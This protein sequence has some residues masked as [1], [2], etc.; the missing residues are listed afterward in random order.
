MKSIEVKK[1]IYWVGSLDPGLRIFDIIMYTPYGTT[2]N[3]YVVKGTE[4]V[5]LFETVKE[6]TFDQYLDRLNNMDI[7]ISTIDYIVVDHTEP[8]HA[9]S[10]G[11][12]LELAPNAKVVGSKCAIGFLR[13][14]INIPF[15]YIEVSDGDT[16]SLGNKTLRFISAPFLHWPD[17]I[18]T[19]IE[20]DKLLMTCDSF[21]SHYCCNGIFNDKIENKKD[22]FEALEYYFNM[23]MGPFKPYAAKAISKIEKLDIDI[24]CPGH[25]PVL[26]ENPLE[27][28]NIYKN[29]CVPTLKFPE[30]LITICYVS[31]YGYT[32]K[33]ANKIAEGINTTGNF[34]INLFDVINHD[35]SDI[36]ESINNSKG[37]LFGTPTINGDA[38]KPI[39]DVLINLNPLTHCCKLAGAFG[40]FGWSGEG[41]P[42]VAQRLKQLKMNVVDP[43]KFKFNPSE[44]ELNASFLYGCNFANTLRGSETNKT[45]IKPTKKWKCLVCNE[46]FEGDTAPD[47]CPA[48]GATS[49]QFIEIKEDLITFKSTKNEHI[50]IIGNGIAGLSAAE[51]IRARNKICKISIISDENS[52]TYYRPSLSDGLGDELNYDN[53]FVKPYSWYIDNDIDLQLNSKVISINTSANTLILSS[54]KE[55]HYDKLI[56]AN[57]SRNF[58][59]PIAGN[60]KKGVFTL[61]N[62]ADLENI[63]DYLPSVKTVS[64]IG[65]GILGVEA[66]VSLRS[67]GINVNVIEFAN[68]LMA[69]QLD[70]TA[71]SVLERKLSENG[72]N[73]ITGDSV[74]S[75][76]GTD[77]VK[78]VLLNSNK[79]LEC[80]M[81]IFSVGI[82]S[83]LDLIKNTNI[84]FDKGIIVNEKMETNI[85][86]I[87]ACGDVCEYKGSV[88][89]NWA[90]S[91]EMG[92]TAGIAASGDTYKF[93]NFINSLVFNELDIE[94]V[95]CGDV[96]STSS[97]IFSNPDH[98]L[99]KKFLF[100][101]DI[102]VGGILV[103]SSKYLPNLL[104]AIE[105]SNSLKDVVNNKLI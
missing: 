45:P 96:S 23:I 39:W 88:Y 75:I 71:S 83:N 32:E 7:D 40:S 12:I 44:S 3:S 80:E 97:L 43:L 78:G 1:D 21:G 103:N 16:L 90:S 35:I 85:P 4:K 68:N 14:I 17:S 54:E 11:K 10:V 34:N 52:I 64:I 72:I 51:S 62:I 46:V 29:W 79:S 84:T 57:G 53:F 2:Y 98:N 61:K 24:I 63:R 37:V 67:K 26:R 101:N 69:K 15:D 28:V 8:D 74:V 36:I 49:E 48:C 89:G 20:E 94:I 58:V 31:A 18:Y 102:I 6:K 13:E 95:S 59:P 81:V 22:Y 60:D 47:I 55:I 41:V 56:I 70:N 65:G 92:K 93:E 77:E 104:Q 5:A 33:I 30:N 38:L 25:G 87:Y 86:G 105:S 76:L 91:A 99:Y 19:Y 82:R 100:K 50:V 9:G 73:I 66:A 27:I 42:N